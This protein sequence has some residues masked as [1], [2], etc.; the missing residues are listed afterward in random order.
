MNVKSYLV[1]IIVPPA[2]V[3]VGTCPYNF[4]LDFFAGFIAT[5][6]II[7]VGWKK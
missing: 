2:M 3:F 7:L 1:G 5:T 4:Y 6:L